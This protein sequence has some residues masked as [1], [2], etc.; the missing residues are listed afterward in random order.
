MQPEPALY[1]KFGEALRLRP[2]QD[3]QMQESE[4]A[5]RLKAAIEEKRFTQAEIGRV[6]NL[7]QSAISDIINGKRRIRGNEVEAI[8]RYIGIEEAPQ[9][10]WVPLIGL[11]SA[12]SWNEAVVMPERQR[13]IPPGLA[14]KKAFAV[15]IVGDSMDRILPEGGWAVVDPDQVRLYSGKV[16]LIENEEH[17]TTIK[18]Y[19]GEPARFEP[20]SNNPTHQPLFLENITHTVIGRVVSYG[21]D[22]GLN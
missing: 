8:K 22:Q 4:L 7:R 16:Y 10:Q 13:P 20:V 21:N 6:L 5:A 3:A 14:G 18:R 15:E 19:M 17:D 11:A 1:R 2:W 12:G 9:I